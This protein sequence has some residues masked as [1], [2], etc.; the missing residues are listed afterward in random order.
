[1]TSFT[2]ITSVYI[3]SGHKGVRCR[4]KYVAVPNNSQYEICATC[5]N[6]YS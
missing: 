1:M 6:Y 4:V 2:A 5:V 3:N